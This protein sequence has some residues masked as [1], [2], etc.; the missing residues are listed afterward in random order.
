M[1]RLELLEMGGAVGGNKVEGQEGVETRLLKVEEENV[2]LKK[3][4]EHLTTEVQRLTTTVGVL[5]ASYN[6]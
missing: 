4:V 1:S 3:Q 5:M 6:Q 2:R